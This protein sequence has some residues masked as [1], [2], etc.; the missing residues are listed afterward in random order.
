[1][2]SNYNC[3]YLVDVDVVE[4]VVGNGRLVTD[5]TKALVV[6]VALG[7]AFV[8]LVVLPFRG[9][10]VVVDVVVAAEGVGE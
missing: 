10:L 8:L 4:D 5:F 6:V 9:F 7:K 1:M 3:L 2:K